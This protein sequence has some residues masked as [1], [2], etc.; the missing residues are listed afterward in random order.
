L[1]LAGALSRCVDFHILNN[2]NSVVVKV[3]GRIF[4]LHPSKSCVEVLFR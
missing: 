4:F 1:S 2:L 3:F